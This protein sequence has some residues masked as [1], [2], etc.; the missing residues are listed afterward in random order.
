MKGYTLPRAW[1]LVFVMSIAMEGCQE[2][3]ETKVNG[4]DKHIIVCV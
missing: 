1:L 4:N 3:A 2:A